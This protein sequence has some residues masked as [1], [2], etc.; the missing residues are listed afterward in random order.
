MANNP[1]LYDASVREEQRRASLARARRVV[2]L[3]R[4]AVTAL[5]L[6]AVAA[7]VVAGVTRPDHR[8]H[9]GSVP[10]APCRIRLVAAQ[11][12][13][14]AVPEDP[15]RPGSRRISLRIAVIPATK[16]PAAGRAERRARTFPQSTSSSARSP[17]PAISCSST[18]AARAD[19]TG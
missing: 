10:F 18:S 2:W 3:R 14:L 7:V 13:R 1:F 11:C 9:R 17:R 12:G 5:F 6:A 19:R 8:F 16:Q 4:T 15:R